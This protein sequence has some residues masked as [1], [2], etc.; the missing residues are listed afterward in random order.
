MHIARRSPD[1][2]AHVQAPADARRQAHVPAVAALAGAVALLAG[3]AG[4]SSGSGGGGSEALKSL[5]HMPAGAAAKA[6]TYVDTARARELGTTDPK[7]FSLIGNPASAVLGSYTAGPWADTMKQDQ[8]DAAVDSGQLGHWDG[9]FDPAA[10]E[11]SLRKS[12]YTAD[13]QDGEQVWKPSD[14]SGPVFVIAKDQI[15][16]STEAKG[17]SPT[18][19]AHGKSLADTKEYQ[20]VAG[21]MGDVYRADFNTLATGKP[22]L[23]SGLGQQADDSGKNTEILCAAVKDEAT[24]DKLAEKLRGVIT[25]QN[26]RY[27]GAEVTV[28]K[29]DHP[30]VRTTVPDT[31]AQRPG[32]LYMSDVQL[33]MAVGDM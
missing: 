4:C 9:R 22:V 24:A 31:S 11:A 27:A 26:E 28:T 18:D 8:I 10:I 7:R 23:L 17:F 12:G 14:G 20:V 6:V 3:V 29:G 2:S 32:R 16:Y 5:R 21:C 19:P 33:W 13:E 1:P 15:R 30:V 25:K